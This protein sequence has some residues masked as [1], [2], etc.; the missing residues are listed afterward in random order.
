MT[1]T[2][3]TAG[4]FSVSALILEEGLREKG[5]QAVGDGQKEATVCVY[6]SGNPHALA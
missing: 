1:A 6:G 3:V 5:Q 2:L 4:C